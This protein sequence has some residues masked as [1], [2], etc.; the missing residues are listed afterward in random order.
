MTADDLPI[1]KIW[2]QIDE[3]RTSA[4]ASDPQ[5]P[6]RKVAVCAVISNPYAGREYVADLAKIVDG[7]AA[8]AQE[9]GAAAARLLGAP[10]ASYGKG[11]IAGMAGEQEHVNAALTS[12]FGDRFRAE[13]GGG[14]AWITSVTKVGGVGT[15]VDVPLAYKDDLWVR[16]HYDAMT[17]AIPDAPLPDELVVIAVVANRGRLNA[18]LGGLSVAEAQSRAGT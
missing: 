16:S 3:T 1:R 13:V 7:S 12:V 4:G 10:V 6:L 9:I 11:G 18:R 14:K 15:S 17:I 8:I 5:G 2:S